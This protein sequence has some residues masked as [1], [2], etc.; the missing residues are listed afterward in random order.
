M[1]PDNDGGDDD[2][3]EDESVPSSLAGGYCVHISV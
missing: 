2:G 1:S 3:D